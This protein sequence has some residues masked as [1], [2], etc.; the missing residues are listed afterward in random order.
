MSWLRH[1]WVEGNLVPF[2]NGGEGMSLYD[3]PG[4]LLLKTHIMESIDVA[5][6]KCSR[7]GASQKT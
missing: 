5:F 2:V 6:R 3:T 7:L 1:E 4:K